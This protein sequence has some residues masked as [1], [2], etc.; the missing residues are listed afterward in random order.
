MCAGA[1]R[2]RGIFVNILS[3]SLTSER[4][5]GYGIV[6]RLFFAI[7]VLALIGQRHEAALAKPVE[8][9]IK[10]AVQAANIYRKEVAQDIVV[11]LVHDDA[12]ASPRP[13]LLLQHGRAADANVRAALGR[14]RYSVNAEW[15][16]K[17][18]FLVAVPTRVGYGESAGE[19]IEDTGSCNRKTYAP[20]FIAVA[21]QTEAVIALLRKRAD[22]LPDRA[23]VVGQ[24]FGGAGAI[25]LAAA[26]P[27]GVQAVINFAGGGG[28]N[29]KT[30]PGSPCDPVQLRRTFAGF[31]ES[32]RM[33]S[34]WLYTENDL[35]FGPS[36]PL[37]WFEAYKAAGGNGEFVQ[38]PATGEDGHSLF[39]QAPQL[40]RK[41]VIEFLRAVGYDNLPVAP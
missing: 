22:V 27:N 9:A 35:F 7:A 32:A 2:E 12:T 23:V 13:L 16:A 41:K 8:E 14:A 24:S 30:N 1:A 3:L 15:F 19:D 17:L 11:T 18:G 29:P 26:A 37:Q 36:L 21:R 38:F 40:W 25:A 5:P 6:Q 4:G 10:V 34:L 39:T 33:P 20:A 31:G 28:G